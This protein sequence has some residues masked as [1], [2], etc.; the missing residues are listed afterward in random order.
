MTVAVI[1]E[2]SRMAAQLIR[3]RRHEICNCRRLRI[4]SGPSADKT[5]APADSPTPD[6]ESRMRS[7]SILAALIFAAVPC[8][9]AEVKI[10]LPQ[11]RAAFQTNE[12]IDLTVVRSSDTPTQ[13]T[14]KL[15]AA[16]G[17]AV[18][19]RVAFGTRSVEHL[20]VNGWLLRAGKHGSEVSANGAT[21]KAEI[22]V[23]SHIRQSSFRLINWGR[24]AGKDQLVQ[25][26]DGLGFNLFYGHYGQDENANFIRAG[27]DFISNCTMDGA[28]QMDIRNECDW[29]DP[30]VT[31][32]GTRRVV[33]R[34][35]MDRTR[36]NV[37]G[38]HFY[39][40]PG[41]TWEKHPATGEMTPHGVP[42][43][44][45]AFRAAFDRD[46]PEYH[47]IDP[48]NPVDVARWK[49]WAYWKLGFMDAAWK[50]AQFGVRRVRPDYLSLTQSQYGWS[51]FTDGYYFN[52]VRSLPVTSGH[53]G[54]HDFGP[55]YFNPSY[56]LEMARARDTWKPNWYL[57]TWYGN[58]IADQFR[59]EQYLSFQTGVQGMISPP[60]CEPATN[61]GP[62]QGI[63]ESNQLMKRLGPVFVASPPTRPPVALLYSLSQCLHTQT[64]DV[65]E[66][67]YA[68]AIPHG[69]NLPLAYL[70]LKLIQQPLRAVV[71]EDVLDGTLASDHK[72]VVLTSLDYLE[73]AVVAALEQFAAG[74][75]LVLMTGDCTVAVKG[76]V[77][78]SAAPRMPDQ[79]KIDEL[80]KAKKYDQMGPF[81][82]TAKYLQGAE[83]LAKAIAA[84]LA[85]KIEPSLKSNVPTIITTRHDAGEIE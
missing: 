7:L 84:E 3:L 34:A 49:E 33:R 32:G 15:T 68:H 28:H 79:E 58:T 69:Q 8:L 70:A 72:A 75:G 64:K 40:E 71:D 10:L 42:A 14:V 30:Y 6:L 19:A 38:V 85:K 23:Y 29:S 27:V 46:P 2:S 62:R 9:A 73:P 51:A 31:R 35:M 18:E 53:G 57:P 67:N 61:P 76:A 82:T 12:W 20:H 44:V 5:I 80:S 39:D 83:P 65:K 25:G 56:F 63:V 74:G 59:L 26:E 78:R 48:N 43:Q 47:K 24:A 60:D 17:G 13:A 52:V 4:V 11:N 22:E 21:A 41:L 55:G 81:T 50:E 66:S 77:K 16:D 54:Y 36:P 1:F 45:R 37:P